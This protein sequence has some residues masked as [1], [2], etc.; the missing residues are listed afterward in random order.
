[1]AVTALHF[2]ED[3]KQRKI[4]YRKNPG[5]NTAF[6]DSALINHFFQLCLTSTC[7]PE[8]TSILRSL[9]MLPKKIVNEHVML[10]HE[11][12]ETTMLGIT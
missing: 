9:W 7:G 11:K 6:Q 5:Q 3:K 12:F 2:S 1:M 8:A 4:K 10:H